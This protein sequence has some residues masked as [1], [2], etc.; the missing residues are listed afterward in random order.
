MEEMSDAEALWQELREDLEAI[1]NELYQG[2]LEL[3]EELGSCMPAAA[4]L[5]ADGEIEVV[6]PDPDEGIKYDFVVLPRLIEHLQHVALEADVEAVAL[7]EMVHVEDD[8]GK[9]TRAVKV[10]VHHKRGAAIAY[11]LPLT[12]VSAKRWKHGAIFSDG[13]DALVTAWPVAED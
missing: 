13:A 9:P 2:V 12:Q 6:D 11:Y 3:V 10:H 7:C 1:A 4:K 8:D 5:T